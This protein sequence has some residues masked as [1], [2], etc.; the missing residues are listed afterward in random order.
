MDIDEEDMESCSEEEDEEQDEGESVRL[1]NSSP[2]RSISYDSDSGSEPCEPESESFFV[3]ARASKMES[4]Q[5][6]VEE[7][8]DLFTFD[9]QALLIE[10]DVADELVE[11]MEVHL[12]R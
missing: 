8:A 4:A 1:G 12:G 5:M 9:L 10:C 7:E 2:C 6:E 11:I 3:M